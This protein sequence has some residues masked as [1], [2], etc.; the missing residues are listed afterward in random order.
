MPN[1]SGIFRNVN[2]LR[3]LNSASGTEIIEIYQPGFLNSSDVYANLRYSGFITSLR[4]IVDISSINPLEA[5]SSDILASDEIIAANNKD[6]FDGN[7]KKKITFYMRN[8]N[9]PLLKIVD[10]YL[11]N[12]RPYYFIDALSY[13]T[14]SATLDLSPDT[15]IAVQITEAGSGL[16]LNDDRIVILGSVIEESP[17]YDHLNLVVE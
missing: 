4:L 11:F 17:V 16:L 2:I 10:I 8:S 13:F 9:T 5:I 3:E 15:L 12:Q 6:T 14:P 7:H 1:N